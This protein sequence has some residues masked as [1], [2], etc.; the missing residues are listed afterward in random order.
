MSGSGQAISATFAPMEQTARAMFASA[1]R[2]FVQV[3]YKLFDAS[4]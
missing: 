4:R 1:Y 2:G 3:E